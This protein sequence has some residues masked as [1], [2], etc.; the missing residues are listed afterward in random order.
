MKKTTN[1]LKYFAIVSALVIL[2]Y[3]KMQGQDKQPKFY[4]DNGTKEVTGELDCSVL[5]DLMVKVPLPSSAFKYD[6]IQFSVEL[7]LRRYRD[8]EEGNK[9]YYTID[10]LQKKFSI[11][12][13]G[14]NETSFWLINPKDNYGDFEGTDGKIRQGAFCGSSPKDKIIVTFELAGYIKDSEKEYYDEKSKTWV[15]EPVYDAGT[16]LGKVTVD[17][18]QTSE[19]ITSYKKNK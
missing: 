15:K 8:G 19:N 10:I 12:Y 5:K 2:P 7:N 3:T 18:K 11:Q 4:T 6:D 9:V 16:T 1:T 14:K 13:D 17:I